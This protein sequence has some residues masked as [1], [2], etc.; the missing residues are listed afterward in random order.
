MYNIRGIFI[1]IRRNKVNT[2]VTEIISVET[3]TH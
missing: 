2:K 3:R 1:K